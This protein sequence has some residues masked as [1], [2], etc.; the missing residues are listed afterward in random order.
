MTAAIANVASTSLIGPVKAFE[1]LKDTKT[2]DESFKAVLEAYRGVYG[3]DAEKELL[4]QGQ[5]LW[6]VRELD[7]EGKPVMWRLPNYQ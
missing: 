4:E 7:E 5:L 3:D 6:M 2:P 1:I